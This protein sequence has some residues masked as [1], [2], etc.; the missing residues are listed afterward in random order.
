[1]Q[2]VPQRKDKLSINARNA[3]NKKR[4]KFG[5]KIPNNVK[6]SLLLDRENRNSKWAEAISKEM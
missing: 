1:M 5:I 6:D 3:I 2:Q 4:E